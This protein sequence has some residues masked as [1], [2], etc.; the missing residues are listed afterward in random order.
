M[1]LGFD[2]ETTSIATA[3][4]PVIPLGIWIAPM[5][6]LA[7]FLIPLL[8]TPFLGVF[9]EDGELLLARELPWWIH[10]FKFGHAVEGNVGVGV[11]S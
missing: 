5:S 2:L 7:C 6:V 4:T 1:E 10:H 3:N 9:F 8:S 11:T